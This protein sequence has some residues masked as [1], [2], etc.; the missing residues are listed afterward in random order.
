[1]NTRYSRQESYIGTDELKNIKV[2]V[3]GVGAGGSMVAELLTRMGCGNIYMFDDDV[4]GIHNIA[5]Q[6]FSENDIGKSKVITLMHRLNKINS[7]VKIFA[8]NMRIVNEK[9]LPKDLNYLFSCVDT[10][11]AR[12]TLVNYQ[13]RINPKCIILDGGTSDKSPTIETVQMYNREQGHITE[14]KHFQ[15][16]LQKKLQTEEVRSCT[17]EIIPSLITTSTIGAAMQVHWML[18]HLKEGRI[19]E[20]MCQISLGKKPS[21]NWFEKNE[22][23]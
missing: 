16:N 23:K 7:E 6:L 9:Q 22:E 21:I 19:Y 4:I 5:G 12:I 15:P 13:K 10:F 8:N 2:A 20:E 11:K 1:M 3:I 14:L 18:Q 17:Q